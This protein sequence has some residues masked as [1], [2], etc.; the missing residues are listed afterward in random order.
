MSVTLSLTAYIIFG[1]TGLY[2][3]FLQISKFASHQLDGSD[4]T[5]SLVLFPLSRFFDRS[6]CLDSDLNMFL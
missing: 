6:D 3:F 5:C 4:I 1:S 2:L